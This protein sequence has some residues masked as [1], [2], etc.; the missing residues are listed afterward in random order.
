MQGDNYVT[1]TKKSGVQPIELKYRP[2]VDFDDGSIRALYA[3]PVVN[4]VIYGTLTPEDYV[5][6]TDGTE[7]GEE[8]TFHILRRLIKVMAVLGDNNKT[9]DFI[10]VR[11]PTT[12]IKRTTLYED[13]KALFDETTSGFAKRLVLVFPE[14]ITEADAVLVKPAFQEI[15]S[16]GIKVGID[17]YGK[18]TFSLTS[19]VSI[20]PD[21]VFTS[22]DLNAFAKDE[23]M[24][25]SL[26]AL[27]SF[28]KTLQIEVIAQDISCESEKIAYRGRECYGFIPTGKLP[29][30]YGTTPLKLK[31]LVNKERND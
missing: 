15:K 18:K 20:E 22:Q 7:I 5:E 16:T 26:T 27:T 1:S 31:D 9:P 13:L 11:V 24:L 19:L 4:S 29:P 10:A 3:Y 2:V 30:Y 8:F 12:L 23:N 25:T 14:K 17:G 28:C 21:M 6:A